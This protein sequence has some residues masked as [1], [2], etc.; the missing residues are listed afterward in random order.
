MFGD[1]DAAVV[2]GA[3][4]LAGHGYRYRR[5]AGYNCGGADTLETVDFPNAAHQ[6]TLPSGCGTGTGVT[7]SQ[8]ARLRMVCGD[9]ACQHVRLEANVAYDGVQ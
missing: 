2:A 5:G 1:A 7:A 8:A 4:A 6:V 3:P 9:N